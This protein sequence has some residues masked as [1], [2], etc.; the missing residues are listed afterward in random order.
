ML[1]LIGWAPRALLR[2]TMYLLVAFVLCAPDAFVLL[3]LLHLLACFFRRISLPARLQGVLFFF[4]LYFLGSLRPD[5][6]TVVRANWNVTTT[7]P[8]Q[9]VRGPS[10]S[11]DQG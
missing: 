5:A 8:G 3:H 2:V 11:S 6:V 9:E 1:L 10:S 4:L 7:L